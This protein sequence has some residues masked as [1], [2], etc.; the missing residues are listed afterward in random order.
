MYD[1]LPLSPGLTNSPSPQDAMYILL[2]PYTF[3]PNALSIFWKG[4]NF[5]AT[6]DHLYGPSAFAEN[7]GF[8]AA[9]SWMNLVEA[10]ISFTY[11][12]KYY[13]TSGGA[14]RGGMLVAGFMAVV[15]TLAKTML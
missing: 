9:Q 5:Y 14:G 13:S 11:L 6:V 7:D 4:H 1:N 12:A 3:S 10:A 2:R 8:P 15:M